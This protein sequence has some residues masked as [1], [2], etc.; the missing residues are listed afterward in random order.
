MKTII[1]N[2]PFS[3]PWNADNSRLSDPRFKEYGKLAPKSK[4]DYAFIQDMIYKLDDN[5][6]MSV[7]LPHGV[8]FRGA[9]EGHIRK[10]LIEEKNY[11][12]AVI[13]LPPNLFFGTQIPTCILIFKKNRKPDD[14]II[15]IDAS[16][17][18]E[19]AK[20]K[21][22][23]LDT[24]IEKISSTYHNRII[25]DRYSNLA[26]LQEIRDND[27]NLNIPRY[28]DTFEIEEEI[29]IHEVMSEIKELEAKRSELDREIDSYLKEL[30]ILKY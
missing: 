17:E 14:N 12:D 11:L 7:V 18:F 25:I 3:A 26:T 24:H 15:F 22:L 1:A 30:G 10:Y 4:A 20:N 2:P 6:I 13:G 16:K 27:Y 28:V 29:N 21:N 8:L 23:L 19:K 9:S 5:G